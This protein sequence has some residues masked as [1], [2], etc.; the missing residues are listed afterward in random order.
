MSYEQAHAQAVAEGWHWPDAVPVSVIDGDTWDAHVVKTCDV[1]FGGA[2]ATSFQVRLRLARVNAPPKTTVAGKTSATWLRALLLSVPY[3]D[4]VT[5]D[6][7]KYGGPHY[8]PG[9]WCAEVV[10]PDGRNVSDLAVELGFAQYW[11]GEGPRPGG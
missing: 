7:Y 10:L 1:G 4:L 9:E 5:T 3:V 8:S 6:A 11:D 2:S